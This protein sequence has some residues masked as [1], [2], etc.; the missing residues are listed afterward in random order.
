VPRRL[1]PVP[2]QL[3]LSWWPAAAATA[4]A[5]A[6]VLLLCRPS[7]HGLSCC[8]LGDGSARTVSVAMVKMEMAASV[9]GAGSSAL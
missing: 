4:A 3:D 1:D 2:R 9:G 6:V 5:G 8:S 7:P